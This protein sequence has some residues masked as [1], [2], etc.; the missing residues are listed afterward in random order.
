MRVNYLRKIMAQ[1]GLKEHCKGTLFLL[2][3][4]KST[5]LIFLGLISFNDIWSR[6][7]VLLTEFKIYFRLC[8][9]SVKFFI[10][11]NAETSISIVVLVRQQ[12]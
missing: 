11:N 7:S 4:T 6:C 9:M 10:E 12:G 2:K 3:I 5:G 1:Y 8:Y